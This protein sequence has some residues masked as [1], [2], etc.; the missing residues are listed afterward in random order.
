MEAAA[1]PASLDVGDGGVCSKV[2]VTEVGCMGVQPGLNV[3]D[4]TTREGQILVGAWNAV[5]T[6]PD[7]PHRVYWSL[8]AENPSKIWAFLEWDSVADHE[9]FAKS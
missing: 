6:A 9:K 2:L 8:E 1:V 5:T 4:E 7:G 3:M